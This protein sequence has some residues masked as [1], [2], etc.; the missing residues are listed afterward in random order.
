MSISSLGLLSSI[1]GLTGTN[2]SVHADTVTPT[3]TVTATTN[4]DYANDD[5]KTAESTSNSNGSNDT[6]STLTF[7]TVTD[8]NSASPDSTGGTDSNDNTVTEAPDNGATDQTSDTDTGAQESI[9]TG[10]SN[11]NT[12]N[13]V[14]NLLASSLIQSTTATT[15]PASDSYIPAK[16]YGVDVSGYQDTDLTKYAQAN[17]KY[18]IVKLSEGTWYT[19]PN[20]QGQLNSANK[21]GMATYAY[22]FANFSDN[23]TEAEK[24]A[25]FAI[26]QAQKV[27][28]KA[29]SYFAI[30]WETE[31]NI[32][33]VTGNTEKNTA[34]VMAFMKKVQD[35]GYLPLVYTGAY[36]F[37]NHLNVSEIN[38][39]FP[40]SLWVASYKT[41]GEI[42]EPDFNYFPSLEG[43]AIWQFTSNWKGL[44]VDA[45]VNVLPLINN[46]STSSP[47]TPSTVTTTYQV[48]DDDNNG[49]VV[50]KGSFTATSNSSIT[51]QAII[52]NNAAN[53]LDKYVLASPD[54]SNLLTN[55]SGTITIH[56]NHKTET[57]T[58]SHEITFAIMEDLSTPDTLNPASGMSKKY[59]FTR[60]GTKD[61]VTGQTT[62]AE[63]P[64]PETL[65]YDGYTFTV[66]ADS[67]NTNVTITSKGMLINT[68]ATP[69]KVTNTINFIDAA[70]KTIK[71]ASISADDQNKPMDISNLIPDGYQLV[72]SANASLTSGDNGSFF[73][74]SVAVAKTDDNNNGNDGNTTTDNGDNNSNNQDG[75]IPT[76]PVTPTN[77]DSGTPTTPDNG[78]DSSNSGSDS[79]NSS[80]DSGISDSG[81]STDDSNN[82]NSDGDGNIPTTPVTPTTP[83]NTDNSDNGNQDTTEP[84]VPGNS[85]NGSDS[86]DSE[87]TPTNPDSPN[88]DNGSDNGNG[89]GNNSTDTS[90]GS[91]IS[92][93]VPDTPES[94]NGSDN[95]NISGSEN[96][97][98]NDSQANPSDGSN[99]SLAD[100]NQNNN[101]NAIT[102]SSDS[103]IPA[104]ESSETSGTNNVASTEGNG[105][106][107]A[108]VSLGASSPVSTDAYAA[109]NSNTASESGS[110]DVVSASSLPQTGNSGDSQSLKTTGT[111]LLAESFASLGLT[112]KRK[113][114][115]F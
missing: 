3:N 77:P 115:N 98:A 106:G 44:K 38:K 14:G 63:W 9:A 105:N 97:N 42:D 57:V 24:E 69:H 75:N 52:D 1:V 86:S 33:V 15:T 36:N 112:I 54:G 53:L 76:T 12:E 45:N 28:L 66:T 47:T 4:N 46:A 82:Q 68:D 32:N 73:N 114:S 107:S 93:A 96:T 67:P 108:S 109:N 65:K 19:N 55:D 17:A 85:D 90:D 48:I 99:Q 91:D 110:G 111:I 64:T 37:Q 95:G 74:V 26:Q 31:G 6:E 84:V 94:S 71:T 35:A 34:A 25:D 81:S 7:D 72:D 21:L 40:N 70:G 101:A 41:T 30:D 61:L 89:S 23:A 22:H 18:A 80:G 5:S 13:T 29:G 92:N 104:S 60:N 43:V 88:V 87:T 20:A 50:T 8:S 59:T 16:S 103:S 56:V 100:V 27:G 39:Q 62:W 79:N 78:S 113:K 10:Y 11:S 51:N 83:D 102:G 49:S 2:S 58:E